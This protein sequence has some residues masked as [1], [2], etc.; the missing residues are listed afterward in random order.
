MAEAPS[1]RRKVDSDGPRITDSRFANVQNDPRYRLPSKKQRVKLDKRFSRALQDDEFVRKAKV[2]RYGRPLEAESEKSRLKR[3]YEFEDEDEESDEADDDED[4]KRELKRA[5]TGEKTRDLL[6]EGRNDDSS[7]SS[8]SSSEEDESDEEVEEE[9]EL[10]PGTKSEVPVG[11]VSSRIAVVNLDWDNIRAEDLMAVFSSF[12]D[13]GHKLLKVAVYPSEFGRERMQRE[14]MEGPPKEIFASS[15]ADES[16]NGSDSEEEDDEAIKEKLINPDDGTADFDSQAL[17][18]YQLDRLRYFYAVL[19]FSS[20]QAA[21]A[22][23]DAVDGTEYL[24]TANF[25]DLRFVP[26]ETDFSID[27]PRD[28]CEAISTN[29][30]P[31]EF[32]TDALQHS[33][34]KLTWDAEDTSRKEA[35]ARAFRTHDIKDLDD[36]DL[37]AYIGSD[38]SGSESDDNTDALIPEAATANVNTKSGSK[39]DDSRQKMRA[40]LGLAPEPSN[41]KSAS[42]KPKDR[43]P[44]GNVEITFSAGLTSSNN[45]DNP[46]QKKRSVFE[47]SPEPDETTIEKYVRKEK[48]RKARRRDKAKAAREGTIATTADDHAH[49]A[50]ADADAEPHNN[51]EPEQAGDPDLGFADP[52]FTAPSSHADATAPKPSLRKDIRRKKQREREIREEADRMQRAELEKLM[53]DNTNTKNGGSKGGDAGV[54]HFDMREIAKSEKAEKKA[55]KL[56]GKEKKKALA[57]ANKSA[58]GG[59]QGQAQGYAAN[60]GSGS[61]PGFEIDTRDTRFQNRL[62]GSHEFAIDPSNPRYGGTKGMERLL[63][64]GRRRREGKGGE[65]TGGGG[66][67]GKKQKKKEK[68]DIGGDEDVKSLVEKIRKRKV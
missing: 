21:K 43:A 46:D 28:E 2:D 6:R 34:V 57:K 23:Y 26:D 12:L 33:K 55:A 5:G 48:E 18:R 3:K 39:K 35:A 42:K 20:A 67:D 65:K 41:N 1:K 60:G 38:S 66:E 53:A 61:A 58:E 29:Y 10:A 9:A 31:N 4:V 8:E 17:R 56:K 62:F 14:E 45:D 7:S 13:S 24:S 49:D 47:N 64:E 63:E 36:V 15:K 11:E 51:T 22:I 40:L 37:A 44:T 50:D 32:I 52:F 59:V 19:T 54:R 27:T 16:D 68:K 30:K 25:F